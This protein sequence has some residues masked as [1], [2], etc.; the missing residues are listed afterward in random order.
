MRAMPADDP[1]PLGTSELSPDV[2]LDLLDTVGL[3]GD[4]RVLQL[5]S[6]ENRVFQVYLEDGAAVVAKFYRPGRWSDAQILEEHAF[7][8]ELTTAEVPL[9]APLR[10]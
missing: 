5:N 1:A 7:A 3:R 10:C 9:A 8:A 4:G 6:F 2:V